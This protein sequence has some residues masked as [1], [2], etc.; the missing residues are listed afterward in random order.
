MAPIIVVTRHPALVALLV[1]RGLC[2]EGTPVVAHAT[3]ETVVGKHVIGVL[4]Y[5][6]AAQA[7]TITEVPL[8]LTPEMRGR[9]LTV[10]ELREVA[11]PAVTYRVTAVPPCPACGAPAPGEHCPACGENIMAYYEAAE[12]ARLIGL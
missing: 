4:P 8:A 5:H 9:E 10:E 11:G 12:I 2:P 1:E 3:A 7:A 6:L